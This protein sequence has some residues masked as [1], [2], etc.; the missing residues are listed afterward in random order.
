M[1]IALAVKTVISPGKP[2]SID[3]TNRYSHKDDI[4]DTAEDVLWQRIFQSRPAV[5]ICVQK[6]SEL[7]KHEKDGIYICAQQ[8]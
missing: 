2:R 7:I 5:E 4:C 8:N 1:L 6:W 3:Q